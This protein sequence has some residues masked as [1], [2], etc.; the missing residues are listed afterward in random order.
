MTY[1]IDIEEDILVGD[2]VDGVP[3]FTGLASNLFTTPLTAGKSYEWKVRVEGETTWS[4]KETFTVISAGGSTVPLLNWPVGG[5]TVWSTS[6][7]LSWSL[8]GGGSPTFRVEVFT[9]AGLTTHFTGSPFTA[10]ASSPLALSGLTAGATYY[11]RVR[12]EPSEPWSNVEVFIVFAGVNPEAAPMLAPVPRLGSPVGGVEVASA[13]PT[14]S[15]F[16]PAYTEGQITYDVE[17]SQNADFSNSVVKTDVAEPKYN[18]EGLSAGTWYWRVRGK[19]AEGYSGYSDEGSFVVT[20]VTDVEGEEGLP[21][22][23]ELSQN[24]PN[25]FNP[26]TAIK[27][28]LPES[29]YVTL[30]IYN[31]LGQEIRTLVSGQANAGSYNVVWNGKDNFGHSVSSGAYIYQIVAGNF[32]QTRKMILLK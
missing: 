8:I 27:Y 9:D 3:E 28:N 6:Q 19:D 13:N 21:Q 7:D 15:F 18:A 17:Y 10:V 31:M 29:N 20:G 14:L 32:M 30:K 16:L 22:S 23:Y 11:W 26:T 2:D 1:E 25:P 5:A 4:A 12:V 24:Y